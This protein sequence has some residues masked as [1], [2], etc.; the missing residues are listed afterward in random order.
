S[1]DLDMN[2]E[3]MF[4]PIIDDVFLVKDFAGRLY[5]PD[6]GINDILTWQVDEGY[7]VY[8]HSNTS[9]EIE[10]N[11][12]EPESTPVDLLQGWN[13][14]PYLRDSAQSVQEALESIE[15]HLLVLKD[16]LGSIYLPLYGIDQIHSM[17]S[18][19]GYQLFVLE[20][21][22]LLYDANTGSGATKSTTAPQHEGIPASASLVLRGDLLEEGDSLTVRTGDGMVV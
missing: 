7:M 21:A 14:I 12:V 15:N 6:R 10:G 16:Y 4:E 19:Q 17:Q 20:P 13:F 5:M 11:P 2:I 9:L 22:T 8:V 1:S 18:G 3:A